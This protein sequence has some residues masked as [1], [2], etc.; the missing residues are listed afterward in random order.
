MGRE[1]DLFKAA[2]TGNIAV[3]ERVFASCLG[4]GGK[5]GG[6][7]GGGKKQQGVAGSGIGR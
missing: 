6:G 7:G 4:R 3:L 2:Q 1:S 5:V